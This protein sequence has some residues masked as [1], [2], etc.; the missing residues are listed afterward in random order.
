MSRSRVVYIG[1]VALLTFFAIWLVFG[2][3][4]EGMSDCSVGSLL[5]PE[6]LRL[7]QTLNSHSPHSKKQN[8]GVSIN[9]TISKASAPPSHIT[10]HTGVT[11]LSS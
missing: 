2:T 8:A 1:L 3:N 7:S 9:L 11:P 5:D 6:T 4:R 10:S